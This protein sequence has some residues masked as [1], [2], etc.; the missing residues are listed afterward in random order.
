MSP[1]VLNYTVDLSVIDLPLGPISSSTPITKS[2]AKPT[3][4]I[5]LEAVGDMI[6][7]LA[8]KIGDNIAASLSNMHLP[9]TV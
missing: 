6:T 8:K 9:S 4:V 2:D 1:S 7:D 5:L 3:Q